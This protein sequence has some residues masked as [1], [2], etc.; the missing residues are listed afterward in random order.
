M[1]V[2]LA[3]CANVVDL[4]MWGEKATGSIASSSLEMS[5]SLHA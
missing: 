4:L 2:L 5:E 3:I 1:P